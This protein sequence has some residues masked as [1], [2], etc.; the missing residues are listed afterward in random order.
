[1]KLAQAVEKLAEK[2][3]S[4]GNVSL[5]EVQLLT[6]SIFVNFKDYLQTFE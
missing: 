4:S 5:L 2:Q 3:A 1:M 6:D